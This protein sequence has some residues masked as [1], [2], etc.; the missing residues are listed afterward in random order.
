MPLFIFWCVVLF[1]GMKI[2]QHKNEAMIQS[3][4]KAALGIHIGLSISLFVITEL[5]K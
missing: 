1:T 5:L 2:A 3:A 4:F